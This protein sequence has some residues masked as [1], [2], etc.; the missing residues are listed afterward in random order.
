MTEST[1][2]FGLADIS[3]TGGMGVGI[4]ERGRL[5]NKKKSLNKFSHI[6]TKLNENRKKRK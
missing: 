3:G 5:S 4:L 2:H 6:F 1:V